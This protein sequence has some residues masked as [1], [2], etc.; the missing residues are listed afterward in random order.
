[1]P[2]QAEIVP[3]AE[4]AVIIGDKEFTVIVNMV[5]VPVHGEEGIR[6]FPNE[7]GKLPTGMV[8]KT[9]FV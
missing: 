4:P 1:M 5:G 2:A 8:D 9:V 6:K 3:D 7:N